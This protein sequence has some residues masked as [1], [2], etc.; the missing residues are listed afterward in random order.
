MQVGGVVVLGVQGVRR[1]DGIGQV[2][3][4]QER[5]EG[6][7]LVALPVDLSLREDEAGAG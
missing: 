5:G 2:D 1:D 3:A 7:D 6:R 4:V